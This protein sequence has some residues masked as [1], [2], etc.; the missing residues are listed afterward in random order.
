MNVGAAG[1]SSGQNS[2]SSTCSSVHG[3]ACGRQL[4]QGLPGLD[5]CSLAF[6]LAPLAFLLPVTGYAVTITNAQQRLSRVY[7][8]GSPV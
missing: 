8:E 5:L 1:P 3:Q 2:A 6:G 4:P 7:V